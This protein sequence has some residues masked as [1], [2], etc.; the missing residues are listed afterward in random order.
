MEPLGAAASIITVLQAANIVVNVCYDY[1][2]ALQGVGPWEKLSREVR[3]LRDL[4]ETLSTLATES[5]EKGT[6]TSRIV[7]LR[8][9]CDPC[10]GPLAMALAELQALKK[11]LTP[12]GQK[13]TKRQALTTALFWPLKQV[14]T[15][16]SLAVLE[17]SKTMLS[18]ALTAD[19]TKLMLAMQTSVGQSQVDLSKLTQSFSS[20]N[21]DIE[22]ERIFRWLS[23][24]DP[25][26][27]FFE[28]RERHQA[29][30]GSWLL[31]S[32]H[33]QEWINNADSFLWL[34]GISGCGKTI[35][36]S[37]LISHIICH[38]LP[39]PNVGLAFFF[40]DFHDQKKQANE[41]MIRSLVA[42]ISSFG[43]QTPQA[44]HLLFESC[45]NGLRQPSK[46]A[47][48]ATLRAIL[49]GFD[50]AFIVLDALD[51]CD[52]RGTLLLN[53]EEI[54]RWK[55]GN[56]HTLVTSRK[57]VDIGEALEPLATEQRIVS[58][59]SQT[60]SEDIQ[61][62]V[63]QRLQ[64]DARLKRWQSNEDVQKEIET[65][66]V[67]K[68]DGI[69]LL[70]ANLLMLFARFRWVGCQLDALGDSLNLPML[71]ESLKN[72]PK[73]L[74]D[75]YARILCA[76][77]EEHIKYVLSLLQWLVSSARPLRLEELAEV[78]AIDID[79]NPRFDVERRFLEKR[80][81]LKICSSLVTTVDV[82]NDQ[83]SGGETHTELKLAHFSVK[84]YLLSDRIRMGPAERYSITHVGS[85]QYIGEACISYLSHFEDPS[86][87][88]LHDVSDFPLA[89]YAARYW[90]QHV[91]HADA[92]ARTVHQLTID[93][94]ASEKGAYGNLNWLYDPDYQRREASAGKNYRFS[95]PLYYASQAGL[96]KATKLLIEAGA[97]V[98][99]GGGR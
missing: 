77:K 51:E 85:N 28:A 59:Q 27:N 40:F 3:G 79:S 41:S 24:Q 60:I 69:Q 68:A 37:T 84:E 34:H 8:L 44:L 93:L 75:T 81:A 26:S 72:L 86:F 46:H 31:R 15:Q 83:F 52:D 45:G 92:D 74:D 36:T 55:S 70:A 14:E 9:L 11:S 47:L 2:S 48:L 19:H 90:T 5:E 63:H 49:K 98:N 62:Y 58:I 25:W 57:E 73:T 38:C 35:L 61:A 71:R 64:T 4:L 20:M 99:A 12:L 56:V 76:I 89:R 91:R 1:H 43:K 50:N 32:K 67:A 95:P 30:T 13:R 87:F 22:R 96:V 23:V 80:D 53:I 78:I 10:D 97:D 54:V 7:T 17:R 33:F 18:L 66:L 88:E 6:A 16:K 21:I 94:F 65:T 29:M 39:A 82:V 42:Q